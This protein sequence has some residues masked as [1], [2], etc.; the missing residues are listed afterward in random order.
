MLTFL[1]NYLPSMLH[2]LQLLTM[3]DL[4]IQNRIDV[5][6]SKPKEHQ[7]AFYWLEKLAEQIED[8]IKEKK[9]AAQERRQK[10]LGRLIFKMIFYPF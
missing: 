5:N 10:A 8:D 4:F 3:N 7:T 1:S 6:V 9:R 2:C